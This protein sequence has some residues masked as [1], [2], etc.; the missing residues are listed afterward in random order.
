MRIGI[1]IDDTIT[2]SSDTFLE[3]AKK[4]N[5][6]KKIDF[7]INDNTLDVKLSYGWDDKNLKEFLSKYLTTVLENTD[8]KEDA[9]EEMKVEEIQDMYDKKLEETRNHF[10]NLLM[11]QN[12]MIT[13]SN[14]QE[15]IYNKNREKDEQLKLL[16]D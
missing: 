2:Y 6:E 16:I 12:E 13:K 7:E 14:L 8:H 4:Y 10:Q 3:Y 5:K 9:I 11:Q 1:D 15:E